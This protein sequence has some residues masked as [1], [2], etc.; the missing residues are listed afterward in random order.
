MKKLFDSARIVCT[1]VFIIVLGTAS[2][3]SWLSEKDRSTSGAQFLKIGLGAA[4]PAVGG[5]YTALGSDISGLYWNPACIVYAPKSQMELMHVIWFEDTTLEQLGF[6][7]GVGPG[8]LGVSYAGLTVTDI[9]KRTAETAQPE[10]VFEAR[11][12]AFGVSYAIKKGSLAYGI[13][14]KYLYS[15]IDE[16]T[17]KGAAFDMGCRK[18]T[19]KYLL[20]AVVRNMG[21]GIKFSDEADPLPVSFTLGAARDMGRD[22]FLSLDVNLPRDNAL[23]AALGCEY[24]LKLGKF[25][26][27]LR[28]GF[29]TLNDFETK[30]AFSAGCALVYAEDYAINAAWVPYGIMRDT[31][32]ISLKCSF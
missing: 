10:A 5:A 8:K 23:N 27:P 13:S 28:A 4:G 26:F 22:L 21:P 17:A 25:S 1:A 29:R 12:Q 14:V 7:T 2:A 16:W 6:S 9:E 11:D 30:D 19:G 18:E 31:F 15:R 20:A 3:F 32:R 24:I